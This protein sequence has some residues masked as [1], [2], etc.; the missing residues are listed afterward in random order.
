MADNGIPEEYQSAVDKIVGERLRRDR[1]VRDTEWKGK[2][3]T[4]EEQVTKLKPLAESATQYKADLD[5][6]VTRAERDKAYPQTLAGED[7]APIRERLERLY[8]AEPAGEDGARPSFASWLAADPLASAIVGAPPAAPPPGGNGQG[9]PVPPAGGPA[10]RT[11]VPST[12]AGAQN[13]A[14]PPGKMTP[15]QVKQAH[16]AM[17]ASGKVAEAATF[18]KENMG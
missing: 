3:S 10:P 12:H 6:F 18:L 17:L 11:V 4:L 5:R 9:T 14:P 16:G 15:Q 1:E 8:E 2:V 13:P 7:K